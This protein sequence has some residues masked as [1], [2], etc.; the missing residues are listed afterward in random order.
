MA[1]FGSLCA[2]ALAYSG[3]GGPSG[4]GQ[5]CD[6]VNICAS[7]TCPKGMTR[8]APP[9]R[10]SAFT[11]RTADGASDDPTSYLP[12]ETVTIHIKVTEQLLQNR[13]SKGKYTCVCDWPYTDQERTDCTTPYM[14]KTSSV[15]RKRAPD[16]TY[17]YYPGPIP[18]TTKKMESATYIGL[19]IYAVNAAE[20]KVGT[21]EIPTTEPT[22]FF[23]PPDPL[24][25]GVAVMH[26][27]ATPK[28]LMEKI[29]FR[30]PPVGYGTIT[31]R[32]LLKHGDTNGGSFFWPTAPA[33]GATSG[34]TPSDGV[35]GGDLTLNEAALPVGGQ[36]WFRATAAG[37]SCTDVCQALTP[38]Q[39]CDLDAL[40]N[41]G[42]DPASLQLATKRFYSLNSPAV[43][44][45]DNARPALSDTDERWLFFHKTSSTSNTCDVSQLKPVSCDA[46]PTEDGFKLRRL[47]PCKSSR[48]RLTFRPPHTLPSP[49]H[50]GAGS[51]VKCPH[52][53]PPIEGRRLLGGANAA[54][55]R[56][57]APLAT[58]LTLGA[59]AFLG[60][61][62]R[63]A[64]T[65]LPLALFAAAQL[66]GATAHNW[67]WSPSSR[68]SQAS[69]TKPCRP[70]RSHIPDVHV[71]PGQEFEV[72]WATGHGESPNS[73]AHYFT[74][75][76]AK[77]EAMLV[78]VGKTV[79]TDYIDS[80]LDSEHWAP[81]AHWAKRHLSWNSSQ[82]GS[83]G[84]AVDNIVHENE[85][86]VLMNPH[87]DPH[88]IQRADAFKCTRMGRPRGAPSSGSNCRE[89]GG[90]LSQWTYTSAKSVSDASVA[91]SNSK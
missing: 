32:A 73:G 45:C 1:L 52:S 44:D 22:R 23:T 67:M 27:D 36:T 83:S 54:T 6:A 19:L 37:Q 51:A 49:K 33:S 76:K 41:V 47:C 75:V 34:D 28:R 58:S 71:N 26:A 88:Y 65:L 38:A 66:P 80:A 86:K 4:E 85:G 63:L 25:G 46:A 89:V 53:T 15:R 20:K 43:S 62:G 12:G 74:I 87:T 31:F 69:T 84:S 18:C 70:K 59:L 42:D 90:G 55:S 13:K 8:V 48:R 17:K 30:A 10:S 72:E 81:K 60:G 50:S 35:P 24:C 57:V 61:G 77:D 21:W 82:A 9:E 3:G 78:L 11:I 16:G 5:S 64:T 56:S 2:L 29:V 7:G 79:L 14:P 68:A 40:T 91:Y 39:V